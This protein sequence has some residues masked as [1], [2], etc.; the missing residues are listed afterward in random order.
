VAKTNRRTK[1]RGRAAKGARTR[2]AASPRQASSRGA[3]KRRTRAVNTARRSPARKKPTAT[4][5]A[6]ATVKGALKGAV[7]AVTKRLP[8]AAVDAITLLE[9]DHR[10]L[11]SLLGRGD[12]TSA[13]AAGERKKLLDTIA[14][15][16]TVHETIEEKVLYPALE[17][18]PE[19]RAIALEG[20]Q[21][22]HVAD[23]IV[24]ELFDTST[25]AEE[26]GAKFTVLK[27]N[28]EHHIDEEEG[29][30]FRTARG[31]MTNDE[32]VALGEAMAKMKRQLER[33]RA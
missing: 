27:E 7:A 16:L 6:A 23:L 12:E 24:K 18:H 17:A 10:E 21:E 1:Q 2:K 5:K 14:T 19:S 28:L 32:L 31:L 11:Q 4:A 25:T 3:V 26:W 29:E 20:F 33:R 13:R 8:G 30:M 22:H 15:K 9:T